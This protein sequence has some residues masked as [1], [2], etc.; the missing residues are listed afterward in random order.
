M[1]EPPL[2]DRE[3]RIVRGML[4]EYHYSMQRGQ[5]RHREWSAARVGLVTFAA[6]VAGVAAL[7]TFIIALLTHV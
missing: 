6:V 2:T 7:G 3:L 5:R 4:D 1:P